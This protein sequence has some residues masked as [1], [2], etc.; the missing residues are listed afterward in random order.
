M[1]AALRTLAKDGW[2]IGIAAAAALA[3]VAVQV[4]EAAIYVVIQIIDGFPYPEEEPTLGFGNFSYP[5]AAEVNGHLVSFE[6][7]VRSTILFVLVVPLAAFAL[8]AT[9]SDDDRPSGD[10]DA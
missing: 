8:H 9:R 4:L 10:P 6:D 3:Y 1:L 7:L 2:V 5:W